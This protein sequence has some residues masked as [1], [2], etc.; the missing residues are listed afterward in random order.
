MRIFARHLSAF[1]PATEVPPVDVLPGFYRR[2][3][4]YLYS[5]EEIRRLLRAAGALT[6][7][8]RG[9]TYRCLLGLLAVSGMR[10]GEACRL[11]RVDVDLPA[12][13]ITS[14][15]PSSANPGKSLCMP[16]LSRPSPA[17]PRPGPTPLRLGLHCVLRVHPRN[18]GEPEPGGPHL[19]G[20]VAGRGDHRHR[21][22]HPP[23]T[24]CMIS[25]TPSPLP[26]CW[27]GTATTAMPP[28]DC[29]CC[30]PTSATSTRSPRTGT[31]KAPRN[32]WP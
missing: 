18:P 1:D 23:P 21:A 2:V 7:P 16:A 10:I 20:V 27:T 9:A 3:T 19:P 32:C 22:G 24:V 4:P 30:R 13:L 14:G 8:L 29:R 11:D 25:G 5:P 15:T 12:A 17:T 26:P 28:P 6:P 31:C